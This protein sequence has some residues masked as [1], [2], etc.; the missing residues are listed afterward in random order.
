MNRYK[1]IIPIHFNT[2]NQFNIRFNILFQSV[3]VQVGRLYHMLMLQLLGLQ[4]VVPVVVCNPISM[5]LDSEI[6]DE[7]SMYVD[8]FSSMAAIFWFKGFR[9][10]LSALHAWISREWEPLISDKAQIYPVARGFSI[11][12]FASTDDRNAILHYGFS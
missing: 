5:D 8:D 12:K 9:P 3:V 2:I 4:E 11:V 10:S 1:S 6:S 7:I